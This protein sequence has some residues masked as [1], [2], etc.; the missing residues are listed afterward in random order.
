MGPKDLIWITIGVVF[1]ALVTRS[2]AKEEESPSF[3]AL[4]N[5]I[6]SLKKA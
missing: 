3:L 2:K 6:A 1:I 5:T 4:D